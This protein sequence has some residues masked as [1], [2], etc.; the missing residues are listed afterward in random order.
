MFGVNDLPVLVI[1]A[2]IGGLAAAVALRRAGVPVAVYERAPVLGEV[3]AGLGLLSNAV[4]VLDALGLGDV[5]R[6]EARPLVTGQF[7]TSA[8][9]V[10]QSVPMAEAAAPGAPP[11]FVVHR[12]DLHRWLLSALPPGFVYTGRECV[13]IADNGRGERAT[14]ADG[15]H[16][17]GV[18]LV[19]ADGFASVVRRHL[20]GERA[21]R[22]SGQTCYRGV[23]AFT[24]REPDVL[25]EIQGRGRRASVIYLGNGRTYWW[26]AVNAPAGERDDPAGRRDA[27][28]AWYRGWPFDVPEAIAATDPADILRNDLQ[29]IAPLKRWGRGRVT[30]LGDAAHPMT[31][32]L[33]QGACSAIEDAMVL[34]R[35]LGR[36]AKQAA[37]GNGAA[38]AADDPSAALAAYERERLPRAGMLVKHS[39]QFGVQGRWKHPLAVAV[40][41]NLTAVVPRAIL[42]RRFRGYIGYDAGTLDA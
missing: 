12:A 17:D 16:A 10:L 3:G 19:G 5:V 6:A 30:L 42:L 40:R 25:R 26:A 31:P 38:A 29:D 13:G 33:G 15:S 18:A 39:W 1:G 41:D 24:P 22:Y 14:F 2:G 9:R 32:N 23:A 7:C 27:L 28:L 20:W 37:A 35:H 8:G 4:R 21:V 11:S 36:H 34:A